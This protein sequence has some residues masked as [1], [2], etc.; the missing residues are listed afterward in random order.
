[1]TIEQFAAEVEED[2]KR[3]RQRKHQK[4]VRE[5]ELAGKEPPPPLNI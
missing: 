2:T 3:Y 1:M 5:A 4:L